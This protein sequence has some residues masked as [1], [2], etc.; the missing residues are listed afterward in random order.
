MSTLWIIFF[1]ILKQCSMF[2]QFTF[3]FLIICSWFLCW[4][5]FFK[6]VPK[7]WNDLVLSIHWVT[8]YEN[9]HIIFYQ[10]SSWDLVG[11]IFDEFQIDYGDFQNYLCHTSFK[12]GKFRVFLSILFNFCYITR[13]GWNFGKFPRYFFWIGPRST[14]KWHI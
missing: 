1:F 6:I 5:Q 11:I 2:I 14:L 9:F 7:L 3:F 4:I 10:S 8:Q 12:V 13:V